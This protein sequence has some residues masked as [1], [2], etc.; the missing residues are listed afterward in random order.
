MKPR[1]GYVRLSTEDQAD[2]NALDQQK[3]RLLKAGAE[4]IYCDI[5]SGRN[6]NREQIKKVLELVAHQEVSAVYATRWDRISRN[7]QLYEEIKKIFRD[8]G[9][10]LQLLDQ[11]EIDLTT[12][13]GELN[14]DLQIIFAVHES[15]MLRERINKGFEYR[16]SRNVAWTRPPWGCIIVD[17]KYELDHLPLLYCLLIHRP[18]NYLAL[19]DEPDD[20]EQLISLSRAKIARELFDY[21]LQVRKPTKLL[22]YL[23]D[24][25]GLQKNQDLIVPALKDFPT[26]RRGIQQWLQNPVFQGHTAYQ[27]YKANGGV[28]TPD[29]WDIRRD[30]HPLH[31]L[32]SEAEAQ[33]IQ[34]IL[35]ANSKRFGQLDATFYLTG[36]IF[37]QKCKSKCSLKRGGGYAYYGC[38]H[39][40]TVC[41]NRKVVRIVKIEQA[42]ITKLVQRAWEI[43]Q[44]PKGSLKSEKLLN[45]ERQ[46]E[47]L[48]KIPDSDFSP[49]LKEAKEKLLKEIETE[50]SQTNDI[51]AQLLCHPTSQKINF[52]YSLNQQE[53][54]IFYDQLL[55]RVVILDGEVSE[56][57]LKI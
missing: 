25:Y 44:L 30:T 31:C 1:V 24:N 10:K 13:S 15:R 2:T 57:L 50:R 17:D 39:S 18:D 32:I 19:A 5:D 36:H 56:V 51:A 20:S 8:S 49:V 53:R 11:G 48:D 46:Y 38:Q 41:S 22:R 29:Q 14:S 34:A 47:H 54:E 52:W 21:F 3:A 35:A 7:S 12:A 33:E 23:Q 4:R 9:V 26:S 27:K 28:K 16:R 37:C 40:S 43:N 45:L 6:P 42:I 55:D